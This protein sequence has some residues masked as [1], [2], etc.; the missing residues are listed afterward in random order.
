MASTTTETTTPTSAGKSEV[1]PQQAPAIS[2]L[3]PDEVAACLRTG[4]PV[5]ELL[6]LGENIWETMYGFGFRNFI[7]AQ[8]E[9]AEYWW[10]QT[11]LFD[12][13]RDRNWIALGVAC[14]RQRKYEQALN[15]FSLAVHN[16]ST[17][18]WAPLHAAECHLQLHRPRQASLALDE[19]E[20]WAA[21]SDDQELILKRAAMLRRGIRR[22]LEKSSAPQE[23]SSQSPSS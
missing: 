22:R 17:N 15:A 10:T 1:P 12:S 11:C 16:G 9:L 23:K 20:A 21:N 7:N 2:A 13:A 3:D 18:P 14:K 5:K 6:G 4:R 8:Y 19:V